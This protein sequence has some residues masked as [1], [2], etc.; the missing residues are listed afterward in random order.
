M[1]ERGSPVTEVCSHYGISR[2]T[3]YKWYGR[4]EEAARDFHA[5]KDHSRRPH[6]HPRSVPRPVVEREVALRRKTRYG[7]GGWPITCPYTLRHDYPPCLSIL[8]KIDCAIKLKLMVILA[9]GQGEVHRQ[10]RCR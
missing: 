10:A 5:L 2:K 6:G 3:F 4:Y 8:F 9:K 1:H 7:P